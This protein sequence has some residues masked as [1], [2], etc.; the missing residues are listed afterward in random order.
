LGIFILPVT[1][2]PVLSKVSVGSVGMMVVVGFVV[3]TV[4]V[5]LVVEAV[6]VLLVSLGLDFRQAVKR[7][8]DSSTTRES[9]RKFFMVLPPFFFGPK[10][11]CHEK[12]KPNWET[13]SYLP[14][15]AWAGNFYN[16]FPCFR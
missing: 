8:M 16:Y 14:R 10:L 6:V 13:N 12:Q 11:L 1:E 9:V 2:G 15:K 7:V 5:A 4:V 3:V